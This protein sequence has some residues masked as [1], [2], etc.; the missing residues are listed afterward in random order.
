MILDKTIEVKWARST[1]RHFESFGY[2]YTKLGDEFHVLPDHLPKTSGFKVHVMCEICNKTRQISYCALMKRDEKHTCQSCAVK[3]WR[4]EEL[5]SKLA[6][7]QI[8]SFASYLISTFGDNALE[9]YW[10]YENEVSPWMIASSSNV[11]VRINCQNDLRHKDY[12]VTCSNFKNGCRCVKCRGQNPLYLQKEDSLGANFELSVSLWSDKNTKTPY[13]FR[14]KSNEMAWWKCGNGKHED[15]KRKIGKSNEANFRCPRC[16]RE[17]KE[18]YLQEKVRKYISSLNLG[19]RHEYECS[20]IAINP[21]TKY[22]L[23]YDNEVVE[24]NLIV[25]TM[26]EQHYKTSAFSSI[27]K[28]RNITPEEQLRLYQERDQIKKQYAIQ[29][30]FH[31]L[32]LPY[33]LERSDAYK[34]VIDNKIHEILIMQ[35]M[36]A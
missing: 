4:N 19:L 10:S 35:G 20:I 28:K 29:C 30:G 9:K 33:W 14:S 31:Y 18:S 26:G 32:E 16:A 15:Y 5:K 17:R 8:Q 12:F 27:W 24:L 6:S 25:E 3:M 23:P 34:A 11:K 2:I 13:D 1:K 7:N 36:V 21:I 22:Q